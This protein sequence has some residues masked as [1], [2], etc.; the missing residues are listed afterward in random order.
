MFQEFDTQ[1]LLGPLNE[2]EKKNAPAKLFL[3]GDADLFQLRPK[4]SIVGARKA[5]EEGIKRAQRI[6][7]LLAKNGAVIV[8]G[9]AEGIDKA[10]H[11]AA[12]EAGGKTIAVLGTPLDKTYPKSNADLQQQIFEHHAAIS[13]FP[14]GYP[15][16]PGNFIIRN[17]TMAL[18]VYASVIVEASET[19]GSLSQGWEAFPSARDL[20]S[21]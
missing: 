3:A 11:E 13:Q 21:R 12:I 1:D 7:R 18:I 20:S 19:S 14:I 4:V 9:L 17:R 6:S 5:S 8:S 10:A 15:V 2:N 16:Q